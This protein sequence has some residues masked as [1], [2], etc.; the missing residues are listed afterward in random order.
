MRT[1]LVTMSILLMA[2]MLNAAE[3]KKTWAMEG[4]VIEACQCEVFC[5][6]EMNNKP[7]HGHCDDAE[8]ITITKGH[9]GDVVLDGQKVVLV[10]ASPEGERMV[11]T[12]GKLVFSR[13]YVPE[14]TTDSVMNS[15][16]QVVR[17]AF[18]SFVNSK[19][20]LSS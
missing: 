16:A 11:D 12:V 7:T 6:C 18:G 8:V 13:I 15:L 2:H 17:F 14:G 3:A 4:R 5:S 1:I 10:G 19:A 20:Q 9:Y